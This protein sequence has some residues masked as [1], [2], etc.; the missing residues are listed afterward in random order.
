MAWNL[1]LK[2][3]RHFAI[4]LKE[5]CRMVGTEFWLLDL[6]DPFILQKHKWTR[7]EELSFQSWLTD[8]LFNN[9]EARCEMMTTT[10]K[11]KKFCREA[12]KWFT[13][14]YGWSYKKG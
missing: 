6:K 10:R 4:I 14:A 12:S 7:E 3:N 9:T 8:Y 1:D 5:M 2:R 13:F 11:N